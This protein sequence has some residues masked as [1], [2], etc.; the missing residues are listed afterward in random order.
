[1]ALESL[2][3]LSDQWNTSFSD[4]SPEYWD[5]LLR[6][7]ITS[8]DAEQYVQEL[9][10]CMCCE[11]HQKYR[12]I[13]FKKYVPCNPHNDNEETSNCNRCNCPCRHYSRTL[14]RLFGNE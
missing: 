13:E 5:D 10:Q 8:S 9:S 7:H 4:D 1:M 11:V 14:C 2:K 6:R 12:P 3:I